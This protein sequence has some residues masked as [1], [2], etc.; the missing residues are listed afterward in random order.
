MSFSEL[1]FDSFYRAAVFTCTAVNA[2]IGN[3]VAT[4][5]FDDS[6]YRA[7]SS[8]SAAFYANILINLVHFFLLVPLINAKKPLFVVWERV[9]VKEKL[10]GS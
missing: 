7:G 1:S 9:F 6:F 4:V 2:C 3:F 5:F 10:S 8:A